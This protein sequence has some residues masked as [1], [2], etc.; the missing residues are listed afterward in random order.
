MLPWLG[1]KPNPSPSA[2]ESGGPG[3]HPGF[4]RCPPPPHSWEGRPRGYAGGVTARR[5]SGH[6]GCPRAA[7]GTLN[8]RISHRLTSLTPPLSVLCGPPSPARHGPLCPA[9][10]GSSR[11]P[12]P[13][14]GPGCPR[15]PGQ[16][17]RSC[18]LPSRTGGSDSCC[19]GLSK[20]AAACQALAGIKTGFVSERGRVARAAEG[21]RR[22]NWGAGGVPRPG[23]ARWLDGSQPLPCAC[24][25]MPLT[26]AAYHTGPWT[27]INPV[28]SGA[29]E[30]A[31]PRK[32]TRPAQQT[33]GGWLRTSFAALSWGKRGQSSQVKLLGHLGSPQLGLSLPCDSRTSQGAAPEGWRA[34]T[35]IR[36]LTRVRR[37]QRGLEA[38]T[39][40]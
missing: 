23:R 22:G 33:Q 28:E 15:L 3:D 12:C 32:D 34:K 13:L 38:K 18:L 1:D 26:H 31:R 20:R 39:G 30:K 4:P 10:A 21:S 5:V 14:R 29:V 11:D 24:C 37:Q 36:E 6:G 16:L 19:R 25:C 9:T 7:E 2:R 17:C 40:V 27:N 35:L 8:G